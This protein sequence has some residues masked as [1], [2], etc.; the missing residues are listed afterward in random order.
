MKKL[1]FGVALIA[2]LVIIEGIL[3]ILAAFGMF[4]VS[5][6][7]FFATAFV[8]SFALSMMGMIFL[9]IGLIELAVGVGLFNMEKWAWV[10]TV[11]VVWVDL[12]MD[13]IAVIIQAVSFSAFFVSAII[14][15]AILLYMYQGGVRRRFT[16]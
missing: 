3:E 7:S 1:P 12:I 6:L 5:T 16:R 2:T 11:V 9:V 4:G 15:T 13:V 14:P 8:L 10:L